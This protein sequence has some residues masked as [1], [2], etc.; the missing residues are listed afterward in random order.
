MDCPRCGRQTFGNAS[1]CVFCG[2]GAGGGTMPAIGRT[3]SSVRWG[4]L[5]VLSVVA[6]GI[7]V[8]V[9]AVA[10]MVPDEYKDFSKVSSFFGS[11]SKAVAAPLTSGSAAPVSS[12]P[13]GRTEDAAK[14]L[15]YLPR[16][17][18]S[19]AKYPLVVALSPEGNA[20][21]MIAFWSG[22]ADSH[23]LIVVSPKEYKNGESFSVL[24]PMLDSV[25]EEAQAKFQIDRSKVL[26]TG[27]SGGGMGSHA[28]AKFHPDK[29]SA[30]I[31][32]TGKMEDTF[33]TDD[34]PKGKVVVFLAS[35]T[36]F[37]YEEMKRDNAFLEGKGWKTRWVEFSG[38]HVM[39]PQKSYEEALSWLGFE[40][41]SPKAA[42]VRKASPGAA[43]SLVVGQNATFGQ[44]DIPLRGVAE[45][46]FMKRDDVMALRAAAVT[47]RSHLVDGEYSPSQQ[48]FGQIE[49]GKPW[50]GIRG[51]FC[52]GNGEKS[53]DGPSEESRFLLN[54]FLLLG[55]DEGSAFVV[56]GPCDPVYPVPRSLVWDAAGANAT[57]TYDYSGF[58]AG[59][60]ATNAFDVSGLKLMPEGINARDFGYTWEYADPA[61]SS[62]VGN[63]PGGLILSQPVEIK[64]YIHAGGSCGYPGGCNNASPTQPEIFFR[65][66]RTPASL[67]VKLWKSKPASAGE[68]ADFTYVIRFV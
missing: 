22:L 10:M 67:H 48:V 28:F 68:R 64:N 27:I 65:V 49:D 29:V 21:S 42:P 23:N 62:N 58:V 25:L 9:A 3:M 57:V 31:V 37:R 16:G 56:Q 52:N 5:A 59:K 1:T 6:V 66:L 45:L 30:I 50:W 2:Y 36:D 41:P 8:L 19:S 34:Y 46:D 17:Y 54:P 11:V 61:S 60:K 35:S 13:A 44:Q 47:E 39:A 40:G 18:D 53:I 24:I 63:A 4:N 32:N 12:V 55:M 14:Y 38:G 7:M 20:A 43:N 15:A 33:M 26:F 51:Q